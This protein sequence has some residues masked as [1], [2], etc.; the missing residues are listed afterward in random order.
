MAEPF[1]RIDSVSKKYEDHLAVNAVSLAIPKGSIYG[2]LGPNG[3]GK[4]SIIRMITGITA[5][6][7]GRIFF[8]GEIL[9]TQHTRRIGYMPEERGLYKKMKV[10]EQIVYLLTLRGM[11]RGKAR[12]AADTWLEKLELTLWANKK[13]SD[14][15]KGMQQKVQF[16]STVAHEPKLLILDEPFSGLDPV[17]TQVIET[18]IRRLRDQGTTLIFSTHRME[19]VEE[20]CDY[21]ALMNQGQVMLEDAIGT[22]RRQ[23]QK[24]IY[25]VEFDGDKTHLENL[26]VL[27][28]LSLGDSAGELM[29]PEGESNKAVMHALV[30][31]PVAIR[32][33]EHHLPRL[34]DIFI[35]LIS[36]SKQAPAPIKEVKPPTAEVSLPSISESEDQLDSNS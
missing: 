11:S 34:N 5:P 4:T 36:K 3:A 8:D 35:E 21:I 9:N 15:S 19:Q 13:T 12:T 26:P 24:N 10:K 2:L 6:D 17:N 7:S 1:L 16:I 28:W 27:K 23:F 30:E 32:R 25:H 31:S 22:V 18:E 20:L 14:L 33:F 29:L